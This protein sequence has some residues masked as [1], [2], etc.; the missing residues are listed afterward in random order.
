M[1]FIAKA[2]GDAFSAVGHFIGDVGGLVSNVGKAVG[3]FLQGIPKVLMGQESL[4]KFWKQTTRLFVA[5][6]SILAVVYSG[7]NPYVIAAAIV[8]MD[9]YY[10]KGK[11]LGDVLDFFSAIFNIFSPILKA[12]G[13]GNVSDFIHNLIDRQGEYRQIF[14][15]LIQAI[16]MAATMYEGALGA[17][18]LALMMLPNTVT[19]LFTGSETIASIMEYAGY[20]QTAY[21]VYAQYE[22]YQAMTAYWKS[23][24]ADLQNSFDSLTKSQRAID[25]STMASYTTGAYYKYFA[26]NPQY[27]I[28][29][30]GGYQYKS[31]TPND[32]MV[33][34]GNTSQ[35]FVD[36]E[37]EDIIQVRNFDYSA[38]SKMYINTV[39]PLDYLNTYKI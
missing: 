2:V 23:Y 39:L 29:F 7:F 6:A 12:V 25:E 20:L 33:K 3:G 10:N 36:R 37:I 22:S 30:A 35:G 18:G 15:M 9:A 32:P 28:Q 8:T 17:Q 31:M 5:G 26:G 24:L 27:N 19:M 16:A 14:T 11:M 34:I 21:N 38:G 4:G 13:L 1:G